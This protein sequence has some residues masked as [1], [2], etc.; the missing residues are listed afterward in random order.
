MVIQT[1]EKW[2]IRYDEEEKQ[3]IYYRI[4]DKSELAAH[5]AEAEKQVTNVQNAVTTF[6]SYID[7]ERVIEPIIDEPLEDDPK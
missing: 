2:K 5:K 4:M 6:Q 1:S 3:Y 7:D